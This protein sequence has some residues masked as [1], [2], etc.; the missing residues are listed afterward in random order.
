M[1]EEKTSFSLDE[2]DQLAIE[3]GGEDP[4][5]ELTDRPVPQPGKYFVAIKIQP[6]SEENGGG[7]VR[8]RKG[9]NGNPDNLW[10][11][12]AYTIKG[13]LPANGTPTEDTPA[14]GLTFFGFPSTRLQERSNTSE[15]YCLYRA[16]FGKPPSGMLKNVYVKELV[17]AIQAGTLNGA[18]VLPLCEVDWQLEVQLLEE[19]RTSKTVKYRKNLFQQDANGLYI[20]EHSW[21]GKTKTRVA[22]MEGEQE[23]E[24]TF[25]AETKAVVR[26]WIVTA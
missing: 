5:A 8:V 11:S 22:D 13:E 26:N 16:V 25:A 23:F 7:L 14:K 3:A 18:A 2:L 12:A 24:G 10:F 9:K 6:A 21:T 15:L 20:P 19:P 4:G 1:S 17:Q